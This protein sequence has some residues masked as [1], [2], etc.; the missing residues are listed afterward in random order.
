M[1]KVNLRTIIF[2]IIL[3]GIILTLS[4]CV[5]DQK[6]FGGDIIIASIF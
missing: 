1:R 3:L 2:I 5:E 4:G 6:A